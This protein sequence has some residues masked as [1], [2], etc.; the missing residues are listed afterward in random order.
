MPTLIM[1]K[2]DGDLD[3]SIKARVMSFLQK[4][5]ADDTAPGLHIEPIHGAV[6]PRVRTGRVD[7]FWRAVLFR[8]DSNAEPHYVVHGIWPHDK[9]I[10]IAERTRLRVNP[11]NGLP[12]FDQ[13]S[14]G[15]PSVG[16]PSVG[17]P[18]F[19][20]PSVDQPPADETTQPP[21][22]ST[23]SAAQVAS[24]AKPLLQCLGRTSAE[25][26]DR[27]G[28][29]ASIAS[30]ALDAPDEDALLT[31]AQ[32]HGG[33]IGLI[34]VDLATGDT[35]DTIVERMQLSAPTSTDADTD[36][37]ESLQQ[38]AARAQFAFVEGQD[39]LRRVI[40]TGDFGAWRVFLHPQQR[41]YVD[42]SYNGAFRL[43]GGA[44]TGKTVVL[45]HRARRLARDHPEARVVLTTFTTNLAASLRDSRAQLDSSVPAAAELGA[46]GVHI[47]GIDAVAAA[48]IR[49]ARPTI[50]G[51]TQD[52]LGEARTAVNTRAP[53]TRWRTVLDAATTSL[54]PQIANET[55]LRSEYTLVV[56]PG[57]IRSEQDRPGS[58][59]RATGRGYERS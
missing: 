44:G 10:G 48:V 17:Q 2:L 5:A 47:A 57:R 28:I 53:R 33:W 34:L 56:L 1:G 43:S 54:S 36:L 41:R 59:V 12:Q 16:Q 22:V 52:V 32:L 38:P 37:L 55:F 51:A 46:P 13:P 11:V 26:T 49:S 31:L 8:I 35:V 3:G 7:Q 40:E 50:A 9:A 20:Q 29:P 15:Q 4:L 23:L 30:Q 58:L 6:D 18:Q 39:E 45:V 14:V 19:D 25:L 27:L 21:P 24:V 42:S